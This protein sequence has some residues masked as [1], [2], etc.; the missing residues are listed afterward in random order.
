MV[1]FKQ[2]MILLVLSLLAIF[3]KHELLYVLH[4]LAFIYQHLAAGINHILPQNPW[5]KLFVLAI[6][7][8][9]CTLIIAAAIGGI[10]CLFKKPFN[11]WFAPA[12]WVCWII[13]SVTIIIQGT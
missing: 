8:M 11:K 4:G 5:V 2:W 13:L 10:G 3:F 6:V 7:L 9:V 1:I 12:A